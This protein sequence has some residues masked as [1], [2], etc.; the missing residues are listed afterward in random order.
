MATK[1][2]RST[3]SKSWKHKTK[4]RNRAKQGESSIKRKIGRRSQDVESEQIMSIKFIRALP[5]QVARSPPHRHK[6][7]TFGSFRNPN[8]IRSK[9]NIESS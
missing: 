7:R 3:D 6:I 1:S 2:K 4:G 8:K 9:N 5:L